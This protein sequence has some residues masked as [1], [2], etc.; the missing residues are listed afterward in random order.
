MKT[1][2]VPQIGGLDELLAILSDPRRFKAHLAQLKGALEE[3][4]EAAGGIEALREAGSFRNKA[5]G[6]MAEA[7]GVLAAARE[8][9][10]ALRSQA[11][12]EAEEV[13]SAKDALAERI[14]GFEQELVE[15]R[16]D[17]ARVHAAAG[18]WEKEKATQK[19]ELAA[20]AEELD[21]RAVKLAGEETAVRGR[22]EA[23]TAALE[24]TA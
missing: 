24:G 22:L 16:R 7:A 11:A 12:K 2:T 18:A 23:A 19:A 3:L 14:R 6:A 20:K 10:E 15:L 9:A 4:Q 8:E 21:L 1:V 17:Q 5:K 13:R